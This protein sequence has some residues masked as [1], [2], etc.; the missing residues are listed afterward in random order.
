MLEHNDANT[1]TKGETVS[2]SYDDLPDGSETL[3][4]TKRP[5]DRNSENTTNFVVLLITGAMAPSLSHTLNLFLG[6]ENNLWTTDRLLILLS[7]SLSGLLV[8]T[9]AKKQICHRSEK[10][11]FINKGVVSG[12]YDIIFIAIWCIP[13]IATC[14]CFDT[15]AF[16]IINSIYIVF[17]LIILLLNM[18]TG[19]ITPNFLPSLLMSLF[20]AA[21]FGIVYAIPSLRETMNTWIND[22]GI[23][24]FIILLCVICPLTTA[25]ESI[26][27]KISTYVKNKRNR[28]S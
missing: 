12:D 23:W 7:A 28:S 25:C 1:N 24:I 9:E 3:K 14:I 26:F 5:N 13:I 15:T 27:Q 8:A 17:T 16:A 18:R 6:A 4:G 10:N 20:A 2:K 11:N 19:I 22:I 21:L